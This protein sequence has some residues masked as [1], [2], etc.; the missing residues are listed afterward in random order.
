[1][2]LDVAAAF[3][4]SPHRFRKKLRPKHQALD[5]F[6]LAIDLLRFAGQPDRL[7]PRPLL[8]RVARAGG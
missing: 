2:R 1:V 8:E 5:A 6:E 3:G 7:D 4:P